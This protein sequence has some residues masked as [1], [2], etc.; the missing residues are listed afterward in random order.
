MQRIFLAII[1][2]MNMGLA[3]S[4]PKIAFLVQLGVIVLL[5]IGGFSRWCLSLEIL[6]Q[7]L[8]PCEEK[9]R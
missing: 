7:F 8:P 1:L 6:R 3:V 5:L 9:R 2:G 4:Q